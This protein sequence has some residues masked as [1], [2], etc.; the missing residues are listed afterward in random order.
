MEFFKELNEN[1]QIKIKS[2]DKVKNMILQMKQAGIEK[3]HVISDFDSTLTKYWDTKK[4]TRSVSS[5]CVIG[6]FPKYSMEF[7]AA[8]E[9]LY[10][11]YYPIEISQVIPLETKKNVYKSY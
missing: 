9:A 1:Q 5:H 11:H 8:T 10:A 6:K 7:R 3:I 2:F 4:N